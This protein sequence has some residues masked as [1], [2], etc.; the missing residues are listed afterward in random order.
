MKDKRIAIIQKQIIMEIII[1]WL[2]SC[3]NFKANLK[4]LVEW[5]WRVLA[6]VRLSESRRISKSA[7]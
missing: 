4:I 2:E 7:I 5:F 3:K 1:W 6:Q